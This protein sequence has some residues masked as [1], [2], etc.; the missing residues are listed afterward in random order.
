MALVCQSAGYGFNSWPFHFYVETWTFS[1]LHRNMDSNIIASFVKNLLLVYLPVGSM[2][3]EREI[4]VVVLLYVMPLSRRHAFF[5]KLFF[6][7]SGLTGFCK[8][9]L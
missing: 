4:N 2:V 9:N 5:V 8:K 1:L 6:F 3:L 7:T